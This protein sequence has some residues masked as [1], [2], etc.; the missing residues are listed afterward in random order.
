[1]SANI[2]GSTKWCSTLCVAAEQFDGRDCLW[3]EQYRLDLVDCFGGPWRCWRRSNKDI[4]CVH[5]GCQYSH[6]ELLL[7]W[8]C[9]GSIRSQNV[10]PDFAFH[11]K[12]RLRLTSSITRFGALLRGVL[13]SGL[14]RAGYLL[15]YHPHRQ[16]V[17]REQEL[18]DEL[19][20]WL[21]CCLVLRSVCF[22]LSMA[23]ISKGNFSL[24]FWVLLSYCRLTGNRGI[25][26]LP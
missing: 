26:H 11:D 20:L 12:C 4:P 16:L 18:G 22:R 24:A 25:L 21:H 7:S 9:A 8:N 17:S 13:C 1:M 10:L 6:G 5:L 2:L 15:L 19:P 23:S 3:M 14:W